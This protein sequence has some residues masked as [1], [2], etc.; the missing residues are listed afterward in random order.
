[1][2]PS[3][4][5]RTR[6]RTKWEKPTDGPGH[7]PASSR[8]R[9]QLAA[10]SSDGTRRAHSAPLVPQ[11]ADPVFPTNPPSRPGRQGTRHGAASK[12]SLL[13]SARCQPS[14][15]FLFVLKYRAAD[16]DRDS[17]SACKGDRASKIGAC[18]PFEAAACATRLPGPLLDTHTWTTYIT[19]TD[20]N[21]GAMIQVQQVRA[22]FRAVLSL[23]FGPSSVPS[24]LLLLFLPETYGT[25]PQ[26]APALP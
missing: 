10:R 5:R 2:V 13:T 22:L 8:G 1:L 25:R 18:P 11:L 23:G 15:K 24:F 26:P 4:L 6:A 9:S 3:P 17:R 14:S 12:F 19:Q 7:H 20:N 16:H 21:E